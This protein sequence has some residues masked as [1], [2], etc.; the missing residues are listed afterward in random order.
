[1]VFS[2][3]AGFGGKYR[4][5]AAYLLSVLAVVAAVAFTEVVPPLHT[6]P[7][8]LFF[9]AI[10]CVAWLGGKGPAIVAVVL[11]SLAV[12][13][14]LVTP[15]F[16]L[17][18]DVA[19][20]V[21]FVGFGLV[22]AAVLY[23]Q[24]NYHR[25]AMRLHEANEVLEV[26][27]AE[28]TADLA[29][30]NRSLLAEIGE[31]TEVEAA[32]KESE[33]NLR[34]ALDKVH[35]SLAEKEVLL[36]E[37]QHRVKNN[38]QIIVSLLSLQSKRSRSR[39]CEEVL[40]ECQH[41][42]RA[43]ALVHQRL[44]GATSLAS[45]DLTYYFNHLVEELRRSYYVG[46]G[47]I[48]PHVDVDDIDLGIDQLIPVALIVNEL[49]CNAFKYAFPDERSGD[50][51]VR[52]RRDDGNVRLSVVDNGVGMSTDESSQPDTV[53]LQIVEALSDQLSGTIQWTNGEGTAATITFPVSNN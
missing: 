37:L 1:M 34:S 44:C 4:V 51:W 19:D 15:Y 29:A 22:A 18:A 50:V 10:V 5:A 53:G 33:Q 52:L 32:L 2:R 17:F 43:I 46:N 7:S 13:Y 12:D 27:V 42:V 24:E 31:R 16:S 48:E 36:R 11:S 30:A 21:R 6:T 23:L 45:I 14:F 38:L 49:A 28:R 3:K 40:K 25:L 41:R 35:A 8:V 26:R 9:A 39:D 20:F 47:T